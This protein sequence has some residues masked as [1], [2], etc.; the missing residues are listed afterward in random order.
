MGAPPVT[1]SVDR[2]GRVAAV[3]SGAVSGTTVRN[4]VEDVLTEA[5]A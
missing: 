2:G 5:A 4:L 3:A 1:V